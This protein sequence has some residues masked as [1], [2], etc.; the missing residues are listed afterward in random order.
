[1]EETNELEKE[2]QQKRTKD[3]QDKDDEIFETRDKKRYKVLSRKWKSFNYMKCKCNV[4][5]RY[6]LDLYSAKR[7]FLLDQHLKVQ[8]YQHLSEKDKL[9]VL[10]LA[11]IYKMTFSQIK[12]TFN[13]TISECTIHN[14]IKS[15]IKKIVINFNIDC[16]EFKNIYIDIDDTFRN[17]RIGNKKHKFKFRIIHIYQDYDPKTK[18]FTNEIKIVLINESTVF[19]YPSTNWTIDEI[20]AILSKFY[21]DKCNF[22]IIVSGDGAQNIKDIAN[23][24]NA[25]FCLDKWHLFNKI[26]FVFKSQNWRKI[27]F[28]N[29]DC[30]NQKYVKNKL[31]KQIIKLIKNGKINEAIHCLLKI[32]SQCNTKV[33]IID[34]LI[35]YIKHNQEGI[36]IWQDPAYF[37]TFNETFVQQLVKSFFGNIGK[38]YSAETFVNIL[39]AKCIVSC[40]Y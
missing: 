35:K 3:L 40:R 37:G 19:E 17:L 10:E 16:S 33:K 31:A 15:Q 13:S 25:E 38:C 6:Y 9:E 29:Y 26:W 20:N 7:V 24:L 30:M 22:R 4:K 18:K 1:M 21:G 27:D 8:K 14:L 2:E 32:Q 5:R 39:K 36:E 28:I 12:R 11:A 34:D 23:G